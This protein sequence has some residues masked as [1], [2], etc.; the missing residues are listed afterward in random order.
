MV[1][2]RI[3]SYGWGKA[4]VVGRKSGAIDESTINEL[5]K[6]AKSVMRCGIGI[7]KM[8]LDKSMFSTKNKKLNDKSENHIRAF[9]PSVNK[10][11]FS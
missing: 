11:T 5:R 4:T 10:L 3:E 9:V 8:V 7:D 2:L 1:G 6:Y